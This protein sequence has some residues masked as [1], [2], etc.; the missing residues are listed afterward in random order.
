M[1]NVATER[2]IHYGIKCKTVNNETFYFILF[3]LH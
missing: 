1:Y 2:I 3:K